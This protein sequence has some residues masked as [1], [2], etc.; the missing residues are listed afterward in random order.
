MRRRCSMVLSVLIG[1]V[2]LI[3]SATGHAEPDSG[4]HKVHHVVVI[5][6]KQAGDENVRRQYIEA[7]KQLA[8]LPGVLSYE[9]GT[10]ATIRRGH[11]SSSLD[12]S[13]DLAIS[14]S[15]QSQQAFEDFLKNPDY[16][17]LAQQVLRPLVD[18]YKV[19]DFIE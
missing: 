5:W 2:G 16:V 7:S 17:R 13:Y 14:S 8:Q 10:P 11:A 19:Y 6:L 12:E 9:I 4:S 3:G 18:S 1:L 15:Y